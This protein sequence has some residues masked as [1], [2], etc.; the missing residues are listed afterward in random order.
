MKLIC[1]DVF[2]QYATELFALILT[3]HCIQN[4]NSISRR[5]LSRYLYK[6]L[7]GHIS[8]RVPKYTIDCLKVIIGVF[9]HF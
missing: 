4:R 1:M 3:I 7:L 5:K 2:F 8:K 6:I 9:F